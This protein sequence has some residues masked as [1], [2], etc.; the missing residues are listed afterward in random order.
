[1]IQ[2]LIFTNI[3]TVLFRKVLSS[4][5]VSFLESLME[6]YFRLVRSELECASV[7]CSTLTSTAAR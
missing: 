2:V 7:M 5:V 6:L 3:W 4:S 1:L